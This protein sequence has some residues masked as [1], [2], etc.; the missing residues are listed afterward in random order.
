M[1]CIFLNKH[2]ILESPSKKIAISFACVFYF[3]FGFLRQF[4]YVA[5]T[6]LEQTILLPQPPE[7]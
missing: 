1:A 7:F 2:E 6:G 5:Q 3:D 4:H